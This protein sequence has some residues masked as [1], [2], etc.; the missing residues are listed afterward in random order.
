MTAALVQVCSDPRLNH[1]LVRYQVREKLDRL[2]LRAER[3]FILNEVGANI[4][5]NLRNILE[6]LVK[7]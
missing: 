7:R 2:H 3:I 4:G 6:L 1:E 5:S